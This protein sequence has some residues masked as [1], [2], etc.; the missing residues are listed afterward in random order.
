MTMLKRPRCFSMA[1]IN[2]AARD[3]AC[4]RPKHAVLIADLLRQRQ[5][6]RK[7]LLSGAPV[8]GMQAH[9]AQI[10]ARHRRAFKAADLVERQQRA[11]ETSV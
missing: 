6:R 9:P 3:H 10:A 11:V 4:E 1:P 8:T 5:A 2:A 7:M